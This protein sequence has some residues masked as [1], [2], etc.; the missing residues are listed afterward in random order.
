MDAMSPEEWKEIAR[1]EYG[2]V[3]LNP[4]EKKIKENADRIEKLINDAEANNLDLKN[5]VD[6]INHELD[7]I[8][9]EKS[10]IKNLSYG[11]KVAKELAKM[12]EDLEKAHDP[13]IKKWASALWDHLHE[14]EKRI[15]NEARGYKIEYNRL[16]S[17][18]DNHVHFIKS[19]TQIKIQA[20]ETALIETKM[21]YMRE[22]ERLNMTINDMQSTAVNAKLKDFT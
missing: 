5:E 16:V 21:K 18:Y 14:F 8:E 20:L 10:K 1:K 12:E 4:M 13:S 15:E 17:S 7:Q 19:Q 11:E 3:L 9:A 2:N 6:D 22:V